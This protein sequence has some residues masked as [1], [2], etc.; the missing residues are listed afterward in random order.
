MD[1][2]LYDLS[3]YDV[4]FQIDTK[5]FPIVAI[6]KAAYSFTDKYYIFFE[7]IS[8]YSVEVKMKIKLISK[9]GNIKDAVGEFNNELLNQQLRILIFD[10][11]KDIRQMIL[12]RALY[13]ECID[14]PYPKEKVIVLNEHIENNQE[15]L[16]VTDYHSDKK[17]I[18]NSW[19]DN[20][21]YMSDK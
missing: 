14:F 7:Y 4:K 3:T 19:D 12:G 6:M 11:T 10:Q 16:A 8:E 21:K 20:M 2:I 15:R 17:M 18:A 13:T 9:S 5:L 1:T